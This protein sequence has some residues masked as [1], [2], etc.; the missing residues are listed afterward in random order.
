MTSARR[1]GRGRHWDDTIAD[2]IHTLAS[3]QR[4]VSR[5]DEHEQLPVPRGGADRNRIGANGVHRRQRRPAAIG[6]RQVLA[7][8]AAAR[9]RRHAR[10]RVL[11]LD[12]RARP[13]LRRTLRPRLHRQPAQGTRRV[14]HAAARGAAARRRGRVAV[15]PPRA[16]RP[17]HPPRADH[18]R[19]QLER[20]VPRPRR[21]AQ[22]HRQPDQGR[23]RLL[24]AVERRLH[25][26]V[27][28]RGAAHLARHGAADAP[29][30]PRAPA[31]APRR[32]RARG[33][34][35]PGPGRP[36]P[37]GE[38]DHRGVRR[39]V[40]GHVQRDLRRRAVEPARHLQGAVVA[41]RARGR[42][43]PRGRRRS[44]RRHD[45]AAR[46]G[47]AVRLRQRRRHGADAGA[48]HQP[49]PDVRRR[50]PHRR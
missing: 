49:T 29:D 23:S 13:L 30:R 8:T 43:G 22:P 37:T 7:D 40:H 15:Q 16:R 12:G 31:P 38:G 39:G 11:R 35:G 44:G 45:V 5:K 42:D 33:R 3:R 6:Q 46:R 25:R 41:E 1:A 24:L 28:A 47:T 19:R 36:A 50:A 14:R 9:G 18:G 26:R 4:R 10:C 17:A 27:G 32:R 21:P 2:I 20:H 34:P 48:G